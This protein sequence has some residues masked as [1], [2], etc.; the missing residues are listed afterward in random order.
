VSSVVLSV[1]KTVND[2]LTDIEFPVAIDWQKQLANFSAVRLPGEDILFGRHCPNIFGADPMTCENAPEYMTAPYPPLPS[3]SIGEM[4][5]PSGLSR[6]SRA[7]YAVDWITLREVLNYSWSLASMAA[8]PPSE[9]NAAAG[10]SGY[11]LPAATTPR[12]MRA[13]RLLL[14]GPD[15]TFNAKFYPLQPYRVVGQGFSLW[16]LPLVD[17]RYKLSLRV[18]GD[19]ETPKTWKDLFKDLQDDL[20]IT[21]KTELD[22]DTIGEL[23][24]DTIPSAYGNPDP[25]LYDYSQ[26]IV[27]LLDIAAISTG[28]RFVMLPARQERP[29]GAPVAKF[30]EEALLLN[31]AKSIERFHKFVDGTN[32][33]PPRRRWKPIGSLLL[34]GGS[35][36][37]FGLPK[38]LEI[39]ARK[40]GKQ[41]KIAVELSAIDPEKTYAFDKLAVWSTWEAKDDGPIPKPPDGLTGRPFSYQPN[42]TGTD[43][44]AENL[45]PGLSINPSNGA[46]SGTPTATGVFE[47]TITST[48]ETKKLTI[49]ITDKNSERNKKFSEQVFRDII[50]WSDSGGQFCYA[51]VVEYQPNG[52]D[53]F[54]SIRLSELDGEYNLTTRIYELPPYFI[55]RL[56][57]AG[58]EPPACDANR[59][60]HFKLNEDIESG[61]NGKTGETTLITDSEENR[62]ITEEGIFVNTKGM[63]DGARKG[64][65]GVCYYESGKYWFLQAA[66]GSTCKPSLNSPSFS[67]DQ[68][69]PNARIGQ[70]NYYWAPTTT[71]AGATTDWTASGLPEGWTASAGAIR[72]PST[73]PGVVGPERTIKVTISFKGGGCTHTRVA[74]IKIV[75]A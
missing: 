50:A 24:K 2:V 29:D 61:K 71:G 54:C 22:D 45:P 75:G 46:I 42:M 7:L 49:E 73:A 30:D 43:F 53:D 12:S 35:M 70:T 41:E 40:Y 21:I 18:G 68:N 63:I 69:A 9:P 6:Y 72:G 1:P 13:I 20:E 62:T 31:N 65:E 56:I 44:E 16:L 14:S 59:L 25:R 26:P 28:H 15:G 38:T 57:V 4:Q 11:S 67:L 55:P 52:Y 17:V 19:N 66:C 74:K 36:H 32:E 60:Y 51:G 47:V 5:W 33:N 8:L 48:T 10:Y 64:F 34:S 39:I 58:G 3:I 37:S 27:D 23:T